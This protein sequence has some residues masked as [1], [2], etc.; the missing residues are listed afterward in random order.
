MRVLGPKPRSSVIAVTSYPW[1]IFPG[2][3]YL[4]FLESLIQPAGLVCLAASF[5]TLNLIAYL[6]PVPAGLVGTHCPIQL[7]RGCWLGSLCFH[8]RTELI[9]L[10]PQPHHGSLNEAKIHGEQQP[11][12]DFSSTADKDGCRIRFW[13]VPVNVNKMASGCCPFSRRG[14]CAGELVHLQKSPTV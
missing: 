12:K 6:S 4:I 3:F 1:A 14:H 2:V 11:R 10:S 7:A 9:Q 13:E 8:R 5:G